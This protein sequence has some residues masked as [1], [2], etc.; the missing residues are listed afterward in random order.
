M[1]TPTV[2]SSLLSDE[3]C[4]L[5]NETCDLQIDCIDYTLQFDIYSRGVAIVGVKN[6]HNK[7]L[8]IY[9]PDQ[10]NS[11]DVVEIIPTCFM[12]RT[13]ILKIT[14]WPRY[15]RVIGERAFKGCTLLSSCLIIPNY[16]AEIGDQ[17][18]SDC[19]HLEVVELPFLLKKISTDS[20][21]GCERLRMLVYN[22]YHAVEVLYRG[23]SINGRFELPLEV[24][25]RTLLYVPYNIFTH[26]KRASSDLYFRDI[27]AICGR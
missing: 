22:S 1:V 20:F 2:T 24:S 10:V 11:M 3:T 12:N 18:F 8:E 16:V 9:L 6:H 15:L 7:P 19:I 26:V 23:K 17:A 5:N 14:H 27:I 21:S 25:I 13:D 4:L